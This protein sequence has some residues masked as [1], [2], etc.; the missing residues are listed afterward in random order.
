[1]LVVKYIGTYRTTWKWRGCGESGSGSSG[2]RLASGV[3]VGTLILS[4]PPTTSTLLT[5]HR[6]VTHKQTT[7]GSINPVTCVNHS[8][9]S[10][11]F[12]IFPVLFDRTLPPLYSLLFHPSHDA[13]TQLDLLR[14]L[15]PPA[16]IEHTVFKDFLTSP[17]KS[18]P[19]N[20]IQNDYSNTVHT[21]KSLPNNS[22]LVNQHL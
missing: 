19:L 1:M 3:P 5:T 6:C 16:A 14:S 13:F 15:P 7:T 8:G 17:P 10:W 18:K 9:F 20:H 4:A 11:D 21:P 12:D 2:D 22:P